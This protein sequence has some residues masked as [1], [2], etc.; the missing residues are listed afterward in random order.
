[1]KLKLLS[2]GDL[3]KA[4]AHASGVPYGRTSISNLTSNDIKPKD[5]GDFG[6]R[7]AGA[8]FLPSGVPLKPRHRRFLGMPIRQFSLQPP[9]L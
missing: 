4:L 8:T 7:I 6:S 9:G 2:E 1:M 3:V 5:G